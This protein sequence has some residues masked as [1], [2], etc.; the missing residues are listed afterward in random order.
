MGVLALVC[1]F[2]FPAAHSLPH[3]PT[4]DF[5]LWSLLPSWLREG[6]V[7]LWFSFGCGVLAVYLMAEL[8]N[9]YVLLRVSSRMLS[10][11]LAL[12]FAIAI[13]CH[14]NQE[15][16]SVLMVCSLLSLF[17]LFAIYQQPNPL[18]TFYAYALISLSSLIFPKF[19]WMLPVYWLIQGYF[20]GF[21]LQCLSASFLGIILPYWFYGGLAIM[22]GW[23]ESFI[24]HVSAVVEF[25]PYDLSLL[26]W[27]DVITFVFVLIVFVVGTVDFYVNQF[28]DK[29]RVRLIYNALV[30]YWIAIAIILI[31]Q[32]H[33]FWTFLPVM[34]V[35]TAILFGHFF[36]LTHTLFSHICVL[37]LLVMAVAVVAVQCLCDARLNFIYF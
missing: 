1:W 7:A 6:N 29:T 26:D 33:F 5:G 14:Q 27:R 35:S 12:L 13:P 30:L 2:V 34:L 9:N 37:V 25:R 20:R 31:A 11:T 8:N 24:A 22:E 3:V 23:S 21:S 15:P 32:P 28:K 10:S 19:L 18:Y 16:G 4:S 36:T 17:P